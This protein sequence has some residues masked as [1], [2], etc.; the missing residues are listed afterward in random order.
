MVFRITVFIE[1]SGDENYYT[2]A[3]ILLVKTDD[4]GKTIRFATGKDY[5][6]Q[7]V[8]VLAKWLAAK[9]PWGKAGLPP[10]RCTWHSTWTYSAHK[11][12][13]NCSLSSCD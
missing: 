12:P 9:V 8:N 2:N 4:C 7:Y 10:G 3:S 5:V 13:I 6:A 11:S 1:E